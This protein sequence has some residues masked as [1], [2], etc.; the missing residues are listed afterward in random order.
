MADAIT[1]HA[2]PASS[3]FC[4]EDVPWLHIPIDSKKN[5]P[6]PFSSVLKC[7]SCGLGR[8]SP[9]PDASDIPGFYA[10][11]ATTRTVIATLRTYFLP[12][13]INYS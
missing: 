9:L 7:S 2:L 5:E 1:N 10:L 12:L 6:T 8:L 4:R 13:R 3:C 11:N